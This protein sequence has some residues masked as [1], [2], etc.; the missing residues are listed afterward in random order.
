MMTF[1]ECGC[2]Q[3]VKRGNRFVHGH[4]KGNIGKHH[5]GINKNDDIDAWVE[6]N[7]GKHVCSCG[8]GSVIDIERRFYNVGIPTFVHGHNRKNADIVKKCEVCGNEFVAKGNNSQAN[9]KTC[10]KECHY[11]LSSRTNSTGIRNA[12]HKICKQCGAEFD[13][14]PSD[15]HR[16][17][18][19]RKC[20]ENWYS[21]NLSGENSHKWNHAL[22]DEERDKNENRTH[23]RDYVAWRKEVFKRDG[24]LC[25][26]CG[27]DKSGALN[28]HHIESYA[29]NPDMRTSVSNGVTLCEDCHKDFHHIYGYGENTAEHFIDFMAGGYDG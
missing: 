1:C 20:Y 16:L 4:N 24:Y 10:S 17:F 23:T 19:G 12:I 13:V 3:E 14:P 7:K 29:N 18:C 11:I 26:K 27:V 9:K 5:A 21:E 6:A 25:Q 22:T 8:C 15:D 28:A 2:G